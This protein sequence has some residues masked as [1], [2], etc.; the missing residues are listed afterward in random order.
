MTDVSCFQ[1]LVVT[2]SRWKW[3]GSIAN[4]CKPSSKAWDASS[5]LLSLPHLASLRKWCTLSNGRHDIILFSF[6]VGAERLS[7]KN[8]S[9][10][11]TCYP[12]HLRINTLTTAMG[13]IPRSTERILVVL[14]LLVMKYVICGC[15][16]FLRTGG[17]SSLHLS[18]LKSR[19]THIFNR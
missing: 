6:K 9:H 19:P 7:F 1:Q 17:S 16:T 4:I 2:Y 13:Q 11:Q 14:K 15:I 5:R 12:K 3:F 18:C 10:H 8:Y